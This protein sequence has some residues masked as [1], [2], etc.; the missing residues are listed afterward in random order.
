M[1]FDT[2]FQAESVMIDIK[3][4][5]KK[6]K[7]HT[8]EMW[9]ITPNTKFVELYLSIETIESIPEWFESSNPLHPFM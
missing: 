5:L 8:I 1:S 2:V 6:Y 7:L 9:Q 4:F 3:L